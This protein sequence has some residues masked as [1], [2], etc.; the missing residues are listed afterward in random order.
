MNARD[1]CAEAFGKRCSV[2]DFADC[3]FMF[4]RDVERIPDNKSKNLVSSTE[5]IRRTKEYERSKL[6]KIQIAV[7]QKDM[8]EMREC[9]FAPETNKS[10]YIISNSRY[11]RPVPPRS[12][13]PVKP[14]LL[15]ESNNIFK[16][17]LRN[18]VP[19]PPIQK[20]CGISLSVD[21]IKT[22]EEAETFHDEY[23]KQAALVREC[24]DGLLKKH[25]SMHSR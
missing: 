5:F 7:S 11:L 19:Q 4:S 6:H 17:N 18:Y 9:S 20:T 8:E 2:W 23:R 13:T 16:G 22:I 15:V 3:L 12:D 25:Q 24:F 1:K 14:G 10:P 21:V